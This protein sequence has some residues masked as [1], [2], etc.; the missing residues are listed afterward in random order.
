MQ[1]I[2][3]NLPSG[4]HHIT[5]SGYI[6]ATKASIDNRKKPAPHVLTIWRTSAH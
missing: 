5:F 3:K 2:A 4:H 1:K 6:L